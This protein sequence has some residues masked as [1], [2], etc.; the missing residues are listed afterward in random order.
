MIRIQVNRLNG[1]LARAGIEGAAGWNR[2]IL[3]PIWHS[4]GLHLFSLGIEHRQRIGIGHPELIAGSTRDTRSY[5]SNGHSIDRAP[6]VQRTLYS[7]R[8]GIQRGHTAYP[9]ASDKQRIGAWIE[10]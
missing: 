1:S 9:I 8:G 10:G 7:T 3:R 2:K 5:N 4:D 6:H